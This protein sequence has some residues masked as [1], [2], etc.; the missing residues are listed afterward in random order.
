[1]NKRDFVE[2]AWTRGADA[3][4]LDLEDSIPDP[5]K[6]P[7]RR[8]I[9]E[10][11]PIVARG[12]GDVLVRINKGSMDE[13][14]DA[15]VWPGLT[16]IMYPKA[17]TEAEMQAL[18]A[19]LSRLEAARGITPAS[20]QV[21]LLVESALGVWNLYDILHAS[22][23]IVTVSAGGLDM[24]LD[25][26]QEPGAPDSGA[27][28]R[29]RTLIVARL[30]GVQAQG[31]V[32]GGRRKGPG[33]DAR[34]ESAV[35][36][37]KSGFRGTNITHPQGIDSINRGFTPQPEDLEQ[38]RR[39]LDAY[40]EGLA[41]GIGAVGLDGQMIDLPVVLRVQKLIARADEIAA[42]E[43]RKSAAVEVARRGGQ[44]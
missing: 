28:I 29:Q 26:G 8:L 11:I 13:D 22:K 23:R 34:F 27:Y 20:V 38:G 44:A 19:A 4:I 18:D 36:S 5:E 15:S 21:A 39:I 42:F 25:L 32:G 35:A 2:R 37:R 33:V 43:G 3:I 1:V 31:M 24:M 41:K 6:A 30:A 12:G 10:S 16:C 14:L 7:S 40:N 17:E 9:R